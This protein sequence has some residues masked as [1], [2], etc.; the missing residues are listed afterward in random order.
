MNAREHPEIKT[1][2]PFPEDPQTRREFLAAVD[3]S[4]YGVADWSEAIL[5]LQ[6]QLRVEGL[7]VEPET[8]IG[9]VAC[10][11][12]FA[13]RASPLPPL[14]EVLQELYKGH[15]LRVSPEQI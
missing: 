14:I 5:W 3:E 2:L 1:T 9:Y 10:C 7:S 6:E 11:C 4:P 12:E 13:D 15:G 8:M